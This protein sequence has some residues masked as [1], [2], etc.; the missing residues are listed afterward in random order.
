VDGALI[1]TAIAEALATGE[2]IE[3]AIESEPWAAVR[4]T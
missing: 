2:V 1:R 4:A 3:D